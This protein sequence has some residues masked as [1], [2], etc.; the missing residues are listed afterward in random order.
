MDNPLNE[1][2]FVILMLLS[3]IRLHPFEG[4]AKSPFSAIL[5]QI[6]NHVRSDRNVNS[7]DRTEHWLE[8]L[9]P[10]EPTAFNYQ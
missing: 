6:L 3:E 1:G 5:V 8:S 10:I 4:M 7:Y 9:E 2:R